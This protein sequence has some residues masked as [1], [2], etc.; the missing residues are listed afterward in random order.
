MTSRMATAAGTWARVALGAGFLSAVMDRLGFLGP[1]GRN[2]ITWGDVPHFLAQVAT[3]NRFLPSSLIPPLGWTETAIEGSLGLLLVAGL[4]TRA[5]AAASGG[6]LLLFAL[7]MTFAYGLKAPLD[8][9][10]WSA[11][12]AAFLLMQHPESVLS[13]DNWLKAA[14]SSAEGSAP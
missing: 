3:M 7:E 12:A 11:S 5:A 8:W 14:H 6:L 2:G 4:R 9:S 1:P 10:V 13:L